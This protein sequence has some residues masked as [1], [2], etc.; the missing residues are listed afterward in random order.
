[1]TQYV[2]SAN[3]LSVG[4]HNSSS[5]VNMYFGVKGSYIVL[6]GEM[7]CVSIGLLCRFES[8]WLAS[9]I[10]LWLKAGPP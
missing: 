3:I 4:N 6:Y 10:A 2:D 1:M 5:E 7:I 8:F 9:V